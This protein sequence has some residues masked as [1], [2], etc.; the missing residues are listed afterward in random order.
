MGDLGLRRPL[1][2]A[3]VVGRLKDDGDFDALRC[4]IVLR[5]KENVSSSQIIC[6]KFHAI[7]RFLIPNPGRWKFDALSRLIPIEAPRGFLFVEQERFGLGDDP[8][9]LP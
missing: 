9:L 1:T 5:V 2:A 6:T 7:S 8:H 3:E 4:T